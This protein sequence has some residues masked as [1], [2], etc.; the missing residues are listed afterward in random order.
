MLL[1]LYRMRLPAD[2][3]LTRAQVDGVRPRGRMFRLVVSDAASGSLLI[4]G[5]EIVGYS[6]R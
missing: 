3:P 2:C 4:I 6:V 1:G 5:S